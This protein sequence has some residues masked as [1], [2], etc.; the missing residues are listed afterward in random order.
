MAGIM[1]RA[2]YVSQGE[3]TIPLKSKP[4]AQICSQVPMVLIRVHLGLVFIQDSYQE[5][6]IHV[7][8]EEE[9]PFS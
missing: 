1:S 9:S 5:T 7:I 8:V 4:Q 6:Q 3:R 2:G